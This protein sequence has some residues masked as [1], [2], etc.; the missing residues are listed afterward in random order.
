MTYEE[1]GADVGKLV[2]E[3]NA[4]Y[5]D[6]FH[7][8]GKILA[9]LYPNGVKINQYQDLLATVRIID[10]LFRIATDKDAFGESPWRDILG[11]SLLAYKGTL[12]EPFTYEVV[13]ITE[14]ELRFINEK[15]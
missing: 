4:A 3:K 9:I 11:Y 5:G 12:K 8:A 2:S 1:I 10:K 13:P 7:Q 15:N 14:E 6:S